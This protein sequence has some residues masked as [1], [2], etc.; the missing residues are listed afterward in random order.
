MYTSH[1]YAYNNIHVP[2]YTY[3]RTCIHTNMIAVYPCVN[4]CMYTSIDTR[5]C[6]YTFIYTRTY[7]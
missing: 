2:T 5:T 4:M 3:V 1:M 6:M 7:I